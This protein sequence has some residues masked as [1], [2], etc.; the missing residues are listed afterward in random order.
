MPPRAIAERADGEDPG[1]VVELDTSTIAM[2]P[3]ALGLGR[4]SCN[5]FPSPHQKHISLTP[6]SY[7]SHEEVHWEHTS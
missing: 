5:P 7:S 4:A 1:N 3:S 6:P 2:N